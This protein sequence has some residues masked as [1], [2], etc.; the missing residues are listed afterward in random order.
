MASTLEDTGRHVDEGDTR[1][2]RGHLRDMLAPSQTSMTAEELS[3]LWRALPWERQRELFGSWAQ[4][5]SSEC[6]PANFRQSSWWD[7]RRLA[8]GHYC[9]WTD[10]DMSTVCVTTT[11]FELWL[12]V[13]GIEVESRYHQWVSGACVIF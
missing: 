3:S 6:Y 11:N 7:F 1:L 10:E 2:W 12:S 4:P 5:R 8:R 13:S 9:T